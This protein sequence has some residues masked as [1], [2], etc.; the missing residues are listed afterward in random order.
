MLNKL[1]KEKEI[2]QRAEGGG[3]WKLIS[4]GW[5]INFLY[6]A[7]GHKGGRSEF[8]SESPPISNRIPVFY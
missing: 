3:I 7:L 5:E 8:R 6:R 2:L 1:K 4:R